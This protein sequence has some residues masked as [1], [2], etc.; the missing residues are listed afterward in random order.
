MAALPTGTDSPDDR[1]LLHPLP[2]RRHNLPVQ[3]TAFVGRGRELADVG[4]LLATARLLTLTGTG[5]CG[6]TR[7]ALRAAEQLLDDHAVGVCWVDLAPLAEPD[8]VPH[9]VAASLGVREEP[10]QAV[11]QTVVAALGPERT[12]LIL[13]NCE[14]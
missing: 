9:A 11:E 3:L 8:L 5:G 6:K 13:D 12:L 10:G 4:S 14:H 7:L 1:P 2:A